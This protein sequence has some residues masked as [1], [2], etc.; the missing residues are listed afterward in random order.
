MRAGRSLLHT[1]KGA[2]QGR[3]GQD[4]TGQDRTGQD[5]GREEHGVAMKAAPRIEPI[6]DK[7][8]VS[9]RAISVAQNSPNHKTECP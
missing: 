5:K 1:N 8:T 4:R 9:R 7:H 3:A 2:R 6:F